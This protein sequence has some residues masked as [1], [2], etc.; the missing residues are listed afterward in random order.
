MGLFLQLIGYF[1]QNIYI[2]SPTFPPHLSGNQDFAVFCCHSITARVWGFFWLCLFILFLP[3]PYYSDGSISEM[4]GVHA[5]PASF[6]IAPDG[7][8]Q[9]VEVGYPTELGLRLR[10]WWARL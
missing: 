10:L 9:F 3:P 2:I 8:I 5:V 6:I 4:W 1:P 7:T